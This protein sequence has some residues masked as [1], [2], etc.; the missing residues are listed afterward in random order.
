MKKVIGRIFLGV[1]VA[2]V[3]ASSAYA[4]RGDMKGDPL[5]WETRDTQSREA[6][7]SCA[8][9]Y[10]EVDERGFKAALERLFATYTYFLAPSAEWNAKQNAE[11]AAGVQTAFESFGTSIGRNNVAV[12]FTD[13]SGAASLEVAKQFCDRFGLDYSR[14]PYVIVSQL[15]L[16][17]IESRDD[18]IVIRLTDLDA[19][20]SVR[21]LNELEQDLRRNRKPDRANLLFTEVRERFFAL[22]VK[23]GNVLYGLLAVAKSGG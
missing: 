5:K 14:G 10:R 11:T 13:R 8:A 22:A 16:E 23:P 9:E 1:V 21:V 6:R 7:D 2:A 18:F 19:A 4:E 15:S 3:S 17:E 20:R 12:W